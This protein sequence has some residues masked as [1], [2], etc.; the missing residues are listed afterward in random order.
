[1]KIK[2]SY[3]EKLKNSLPKSF[4]LPNKKFAKNFKNTKKQ[5]KNCEKTQKN[6]KK[7]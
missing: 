6:R 5:Q 7:H 4:L 1:M 3:S 2:H